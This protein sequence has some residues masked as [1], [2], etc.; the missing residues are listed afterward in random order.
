MDAPALANTHG[1]P[2]RR[3][4]H[5]YFSPLAHCPALCPFDPPRDLFSDDYSWAREEAAARHCR[6]YCGGV[7]PEE[8]PWCLRRLA[9]A[10]ATMRPTEF[11]GAF[12]VL[13]GSP[14][15]S[16]GAAGGNER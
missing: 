2:T 14:R 10:R 16:D 11:L 4:A 9:G 3:L 5:L 13:P 15:R 12:A 8:E 1:T 7:L 6:K